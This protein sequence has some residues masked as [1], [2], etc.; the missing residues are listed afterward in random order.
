[1][2]AK[3][4]AFRLA[5]MLDRGFAALVLILLCTLTVGCSER[6]T[7]TVTSSN[8]PVTD[9]RLAMGSTLKLVVWTADEAA[10]RI[11]IDEVYQEFERLENLMSVW[12]EGSDV[13]RLN[14]AAGGDPVSLSPEVI[15]VLAL[16][17]HYSEL[18]GGK[19]DVTFGPLSGLWK[20]DHDLDGVIPDPAAIAARLPLI[21]WEDLVV[22][23][24]AGLAQLRR[25]GMSVHLGGIGKGYAVDRAT[26]ILRR[27]GFENFLI[28]AGGDL[29]VGGHPEGR[30]WRLA[31]QDP[32][33]P[34]ETP[35]AVVELTNTTFSTS[36][37]YERFFMKEGQRYHHIL[38]PDLGI[39]ARASRSVTLLTPRAVEA[40]ALSKAV[41]ILGPEAGLAL[42]E[43]LPDVEGVIV[44]AGNEVVVSSGL[45]DRLTLLS[46][47]ADGP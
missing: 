1:V 15:E 17:R 33:G 40:D 24:A 4:L 38:D 20:F 39:P 31:I 25:R 44:G 5:S 19:F 43:Q 7:T 11:A 36:G 41:F 27:H 46:P 14:A 42:I 23:Q 18:T 45:K 16:A 9:V 26:A 37:D 35:F 10:A 22:D 29:Y 8:T 2:S 3:G 28:Q 30:P 6:A 13:L 34:P 47:P 12:R 21:G 32:R